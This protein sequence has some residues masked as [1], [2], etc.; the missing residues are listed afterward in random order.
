MK[1]ARILTAVGT[2]I[3]GL[4]LLLSL[5]A[6]T[7]ERVD[8][9]AIDKIKA[10]GKVAPQVMDMA[11]TITNTY[12]MRLTNSAS[13]KAAGEYARKKLVEWKLSPVE[14]Q[15]FNFG[16]GWTNNALSIKMVNDPA[17]TFQAY[18][19]PWTQGTAGPVT[20]EVV[21]GVRSQA[22]LTGMK[23]KLKGKIVLLLPSPPAPPTAPAP[24]IKRFTDA[25]LITMTAPTV[26]PAPA[27]APAA[28]GTP[29]LITRG[30]QAA[31]EAAAARGAAAPAPEPPA[32]EAGAFAFL[33]NA[34]SAP[35]AAPTN[36]AR[37]AAAA[38]TGMPSR[39]VVTRFY[40][41]EGV[42]AIIEPT[43]VRFGAMFSIL[44]TGETVPWKKDP[45]LTKTPPQVVMAV[46]D[47]NKLYDKVKAGAVSLTVDIKNT[48]DRGVTEKRGTD[49]VDLLAFN[50]VGE[51]KGTDKADELVVLGAQL[52][53]VNLGKGATDNAAGVAVV[54][55]A[56]RLLKAVNLP[57]RRTV[58]IGLWTGG[59][60]GALGS[61]AFV[62]K[63]FFQRPIR[64]L[65]AGH[66]KL[67]AYFNVNNGTGAIRGVYLQGNEQLKPIFTEWLTPFKSMGMTALGAQ[68]VGG[69][70]HIS[71]DNIGLP[72]FQF[73]QDPILYDAVTRHSTQDTADKLIKEDLEKNAVIVASWVYLAA[74]RPEMLPRKPLPRGVYPAGSPVP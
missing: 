3:L 25:E 50:V 1:R 53:T 72:G 11:T 70:D 24:P 48:Y 43:Q 56:V 9:A 13:V 27:A 7:P 65:R 4:S 23:G 16:N 47:Y 8:T 59:E 21:E 14:L 29:P 18:S 63:Y 44:D 60:Q 15:T 32:A 45:K 66:A 35:A 2:Y 41:D 20:A 5:T 68:S 22:D 57:M 31:Q 10:A 6:Q 54:M 52:D 36:A 19:K 58:R 46:D 74:T 26:A 39:A 62:D 34:L 12:G 69:T 30:Q 61:M 67:S 42:A 28:G 55:E 73:I 71:F 51:I 40:F 38:A 37:P 17:V 33:E 49:T 64:Q